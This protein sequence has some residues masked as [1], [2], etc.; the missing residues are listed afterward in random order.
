MELEVESLTGAAH[1][2]RS[3]E[4][5][6]QRNGHCDRKWETRAGAVELRIP[7]LRKGSYFPGFLEPRRMAEKALT[8]VVQEAYVQGISTRSVDE[9]VSAAPTTLPGTRFRT[10]VTLSSTR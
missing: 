4:R 9:L 7:K 5:I 2:A 6:N 3:P 10:T 1:D 8:A